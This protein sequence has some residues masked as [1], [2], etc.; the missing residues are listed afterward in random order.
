MRAGHDPLV[1]SLT[2]RIRAGDVTGLAALLAEHP[3]LA[4]ERYGDDATSQTALH[5]AT[6]WP[7]HRPRV[8]ETIALL[9]AAGAPVDG[10]FT[11]PH[12]ETPLHWAASC[13]DTEAIDALLDAGADIEAPGAVFTDGSALSDAVIFAQWNAARRLVERG[14]TM[15]IWQAAALGE[16]DELA[17]LLETSAPSEQDI[18]NAGWHACRAGRLDAVRLLADRGADLDWLGH[19][20]TTSRRAGIA[21]GNSD[22]VAWLHTV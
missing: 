9:V 7:G 8:A 11:G 5:L 16:I 20:Q 2:G 19:D 4:A 12:R 3:S 17:S 22:L 6:D 13:D 21:S 10:R 18:T 14:A 15:T 1:V